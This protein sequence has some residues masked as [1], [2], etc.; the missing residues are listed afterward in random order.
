MSNDLVRVTFPDGTQLYTYG[1]SW[2]IRCTR[3]FDTE[4]EVTNHYNE[5]WISVP[6][7]EVDEETLAE[8]DSVKVLIETTYGSKDRSYHEMLTYHCRASK[9][10]KIITYGPSYDDPDGSNDLWSM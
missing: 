4:A 6:P 1:D 2:S 8:E 7:I 9:K 10:Y 3:L 5:R